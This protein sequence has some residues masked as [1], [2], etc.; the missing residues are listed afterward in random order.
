M[1]FV[2]L[3]ALTA[4]PVSIALRPAQQATVN[5]AGVM[6][7]LSATLER[8]IAAVRVDQTSGTITVTATGQSGTD[9]LHIADARGDTLDVPVRVAPDA[10]TIVPGAVLQVTGAPAKPS[11]IAAQVDRL[12]HYLTQTA[13]GAQATIPA[14]TPPPA[15]PAAG[16]AVHFS[17]PIQVTG[18]GDAYWNVAGT[19]NVTVQN[20]QLPP[21]VTQRLLYDDDPERVNGDG[22]VFRGTIDAETPARL[23][24]YHDDGP[25][26]RV[27]AVVLNNG[28][29]HVSQVQVI[30]ASAGPNIDVMSVG[31]AVSEQYL[32]MSHL[33]QSVV[34]PVYPNRPIVLDRF[35]MTSRQ[36]VA[37]SIGLRVLS[38]GPLGVTIVAASPDDDPLALLGAPLVPRDGHHRTGVF[39]LEDYG[40]T[41]V[42]YTVGGPDARFTYGGR[43]PTPPNVDPS[44]K[45]HDYGDYG[46][47]WRM[48]F[49]LFNQT[50][51]PATVY[52]YERPLGGA[53]RASFLVDGTFVDMG[54]VR[55]PKPYQVGAFLL[56]PNQTY[57]VDVETMTD[58][59]SNFPAE[60][61]IT[62]TPPEP[63]P[64]PVRSPE[65]CFPKEPGF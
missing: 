16:E 43:S 25:A 8:R 1:L 38:G 2:L 32:R 62:A 51:S 47:R 34:L 41:V 11:W 57:R 23:Y 59:G 60:I 31:H 21:Y 24:Y 40:N 10:G 27:L 54:C 19:T 12:A 3:A 29:A 33:G 6:G 7:A 56:S 28:A 49:L 52:L 37:G 30:D 46:V 63:S 17:I 44:A 65:G 20:V 4:T 35:T 13:P 18:T 14:V 45:G 22:V 61:G 15:A 39:S 50:A 48:R 64:P 58:G 42:D 26:P 9:T 5:V 36:G 55:V 53:L